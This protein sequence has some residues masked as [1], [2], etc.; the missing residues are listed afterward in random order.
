MPATYQN[1]HFQS[2]NHSVLLVWVDMHWSIGSLRIRRFDRA[3][4]IP[5]IISGIT[6][7]FPHQP[8]P[9]N[10]I[11]SQR[12][13]SHYRHLCVHCQEESAPGLVGKAICLSIDIC[14]ANDHRKTVFSGHSTQK[15]LRHA[16]NH[17]SSANTHHCMQTCRQFSTNRLRSHTLRCYTWKI[18]PNHSYL[19]P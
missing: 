2:M 17:W 1:H 12:L 13:D 6:I 10:R 14:M 9:G 5:K 11:Y 19:E 16:R 4:S 15:P 8:M 7:I 3:M 18:Y